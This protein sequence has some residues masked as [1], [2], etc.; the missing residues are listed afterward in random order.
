[1]TTSESAHEALRELCAAHALGCLDPADAVLVEEHLRA[2][3]AACESEIARH[4]VV[5]EALGASLDPVPPPAGAEQRLLVRL[6]APAGRPAARLAPARPAA[7][8]ARWA[9]PIAAALVAA[10]AVWVAWDRQRESARL[11]AD[12]RVLQAQLDDLS[13]RVRRL[14]AAQVAVFELESTGHVPAAEGYVYH[15]VNDPGNLAD[16]RWQLHAAHLAPPAPSVYEAW[17]LAQGTTRDLGTLEVDE[18]GHCMADL[19][20]PQF[21]GIATF[22]LTL[23]TRGAAGPTGPVVLHHTQLTLTPIEEP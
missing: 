5:I 13:R 22:Q 4:A 2:G 23:E 7:S 21:E 1:V 12:G 18:H 8:F 19:P 20:M 11:E 17:L 14:A 10:V 9:L 15:D 6:A 16:D 3:C